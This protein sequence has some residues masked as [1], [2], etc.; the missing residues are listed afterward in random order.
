MYREKSDCYKSEYAERD[1]RCAHT[2]MVSGQKENEAVQP[3]RIHDGIYLLE[4]T[5]A[6]A[7]AHLENLRICPSALGDLLYLSYV[8]FAVREIF[9]LNLGRKVFQ[10]GIK[11]FAVVLLLEKFH[12]Y[13]DEVRVEVLVPTRRRPT[14]SRRPFAACSG[15]A[16][17]AA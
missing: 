17:A 10:V 5:L 13:S 16:S 12:E 8:K 7:P 9:C 1:Y 15:A 6:F 2:G 11:K 3:R 14:N 4:C